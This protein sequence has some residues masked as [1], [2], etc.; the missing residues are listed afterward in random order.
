MRGNRHSGSILLL[1]A[2]IVAA[3]APACYPAPDTSQKG[4][5]AVQSNE[6]KST[7]TL[8]RGGIV[9]GPRDQ[10]RI[11][12][13]FTGGSFA[14][15]GTT[16]LTELGRRGIKGSFFFTGDFFRTAAFGPFI[17][18]V[19]NEGHYLGPHSDGHPL[20]ASWENPPKLLIS[21][22]DFDADIDRNMKTLAEFGVKLEDAKFFI[23]PYEHFT[24]EIVEWTRARGMILFNF[25][26]GTR[27]NADYMEDT[28]PRY[29]PCE[30]MVAS[31]MKKEATDPDGLNG[32][33]ML[34][35]VGAGPKRT[36]CHLYDHMGA[37][38]DELARRGYTFVRVDEM[39]A[40]AL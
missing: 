2:V 14:D 36:R 11:A 4:V 25:S 26:P 37:M 38:I 31:V 16:I 6:S 24:P 13:I 1:S 20:Y 21:R 19:R 12:L 8:D 35:H 7:F 33:M 10:K 40:G 15:G 5:I 34:I 9:R 18:R 32:F 22:Q 23:P 28:D 29:V 3:G 30:E 27:T 39:L 17:G